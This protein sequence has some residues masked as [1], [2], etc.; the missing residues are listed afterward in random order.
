MVIEFPAT[1]NKQYYL[2][3]VVSLDGQHYLLN[4]L[5]D[6]TKKT[7][8][9][10]LQPI[11]KY[12]QDVKASTGD[13]LVLEKIEINHPVLLEA[14]EFFVEDENI[15][16]YVNVKEDVPYELDLETA[17]NNRVGKLFKI[18]GLAESYDFGRE[19]I[20]EYN[21]LDYKNAYVCILNVKS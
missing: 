5:R 7:K 2:K 19:E 9:Q 13:M 11:D 15:N 1:T 14:G 8:F 3:Q 20:L 12:P 16:K 17:D 21:R 4:D 10:N 6:R 18:I